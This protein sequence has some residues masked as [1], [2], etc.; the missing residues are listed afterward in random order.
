MGQ[1][2][3][4]IRLQRVHVGEDEAHRVAQE[5]LVELELGQDVDH[6]QIYLVYLVGLGDQGSNHLVVLSWRA[7]APE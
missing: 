2:L 5:V 3:E 1:G 7:A 4:E 6:G